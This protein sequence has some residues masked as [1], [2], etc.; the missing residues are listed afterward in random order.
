[1]E[2][3]DRTGEGWWCWGKSGKVLKGAVK[4][5]KPE[6]SSKVKFIKSAS[7]WQEVPEG[8]SGSSAFCLE[9][10]ERTAASVQNLHLYAHKIHNSTIIDC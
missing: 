8:G 4:D 6:L 7:R 2:S 9:Q 1:M 3:P 5:E 10:T